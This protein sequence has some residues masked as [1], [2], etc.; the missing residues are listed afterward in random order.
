M[1]EGC[2]HHQCHQGTKN[3]VLVVCSGDQELVRTY[4]G[5]GWHLKSKYEWKRV[6]ATKA[7]MSSVHSIIQFNQADWKTVKQVQLF[8]FFCINHISKKGL[9]TNASI[10]FSMSRAAGHLATWGEMH[11]I[12]FW[13]L[14]EVMLRTEDMMVVKSS[15][16][17]LREFVVAEHYTQECVKK[18]YCQGG[19]VRNKIIYKIK[20]SARLCYG[21]VL[22]CFSVLTCLIFFLS[23]R[24]WQNKRLF[25]V[26]G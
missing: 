24:R 26:F 21:Y 8:L 25:S 18:E 10:P 7:W 9:A 23:S 3:I 4:A 5:K 15:K 17:Y 2:Q 11:H 12:C 20:K 19:E 14:T 13:V 22:F 16:I 1:W 6:N